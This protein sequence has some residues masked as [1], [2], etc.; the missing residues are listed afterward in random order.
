MQLLTIADL[1][2]PEE[3]L[4][5]LFGQAQKLAELWLEFL[6]QDAEKYEYTVIDYGER[7]RS[8]G[9]HAS[10]MTKC[11]LK[12]V[13]SI[14]GTERRV[15]SE[16]VDVNMKMRMRLG[17]AVHAM[18][19]SDF[20]RMAIWY[21]KQYSPAGYALSFQAELPIK[22]E[23]QEVSKKWDLSSSC[24]GAFTF[25]RWDGQQWVAFMRVGV[26]I[27]TSS[28]KQFVDRKKPD[29]DHMEQ[30]C[31]YQACLD[32]PLM[33][34]LYYNKSN[35]NF[36]TPYAPWL[37]KFDSHKWEN[38]LLPRFAT[39]HQ[40]AQT[41]QMPDRTEGMHCQWCPFAWKC[42]PKVLNRSSFNAT[43][44]VPAGMLVKR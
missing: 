13:Y 31:L 29:H 38:E 17:T 10:E 15:L 34:V 40:H 30:T 22:K 24:D 20:E 27:K 43:P 12:V 11:Q 19:Q 37:F 9:I 32:L 3:E 8:P 18:L 26:E 25:W 6:R 1:K 16:S 23:L 35:S 5:P 7:E 36:T 41:Q 42:N 4:Q 21:T 44:I 39:A 14:L 28:D 33:W 2:R